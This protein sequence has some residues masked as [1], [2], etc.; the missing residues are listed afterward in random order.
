MIPDDER[1]KHR[2][3]IEDQAA[4]LPP[5]TEAGVDDLA[6]SFAAIRVRM[7]RDQART[8]PSDT[9]VPYRG[10]R[11]RHNVA[12]GNNEQTRSD[13][14]PAGALNPAVPSL[15]PDTDVNAGRATGRGAR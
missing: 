8:A 7:A 6:A 3:R 14:A 12:P 13:A 15:T 4:A 10:R 9:S 5:P 11:R 2:R 1:A